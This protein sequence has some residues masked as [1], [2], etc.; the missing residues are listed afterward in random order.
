MKQCVTRI[1]SFKMLMRERLSKGSHFNFRPGTIFF[2]Q[3][4]I[5]KNIGGKVTAKTLLHLQ[6]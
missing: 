5:L 6:K 2:I 4:T 1:I 3:F